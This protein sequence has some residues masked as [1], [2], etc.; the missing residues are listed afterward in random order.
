SLSLMTA[1]GFTLD[2]STS[3]EGFVPATAQVNFTRQGD[4]EIYVKV[5]LLRANSPEL[6]YTLEVE[7]TRAPQKPTITEQEPPLFPESQ[8]RTIVI[9]ASAVII[10]LTFA[11][12]IV[13]RFRRRSMTAYG[14]E[15]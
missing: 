6:G 5:S 8:A 4:Q 9:G 10:I 15:W 13:G 2:A 1:D 3:R 14:Y 12:I 7:L 11:S